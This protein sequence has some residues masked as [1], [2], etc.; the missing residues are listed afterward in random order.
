MTLRQASSVLRRWRSLVVAGVLIGVV[1]GWLSAPGRAPGAVFEATHSLL[2][3]PQ[4]R[5]TSRVEQGAVMATKGAIPDRV[6]TRLGVDRQFVRSA[7]SAETPPNTGLLLIT[8]RSGD[9]RQAEALANVTAE[10]LVVELGG[11]A[12]GLQT[13]E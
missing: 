12:S 3:D 8:G 5:R 10:E 11:P 4:T 2:A 7:V 6:A 9:P 13:L 1:V